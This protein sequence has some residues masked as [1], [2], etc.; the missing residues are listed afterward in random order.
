MA[1][2]PDDKNWTWVLEQ[3][4]LDCG[5]DATRIDVAEL[6]GTVRALAAGWPAALARPDAALRPTG[7]QWSALEYACHVRDVFRLYTYRLGLML[8][9]D[10]TQFPNWDQDVTAIEQRYDLQDPAVVVGELLAAAEENA[11]L[12]DT[13]TPDQYGQRGYRSDGAEF[14]VESFGKYFV[15]DP[16]HHLDDVVRGN[17][18]LDDGQLD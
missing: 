9:D 8:A 10:G 7:D 13:V 18:I 3:P 4:C 14:T 5:F 1:I 2:V 17:Q 12:W 15:H 6:G 11:A 16:I